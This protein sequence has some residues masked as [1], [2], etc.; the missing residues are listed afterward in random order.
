M[1]EPKSWREIRR[2][3][4]LDQARMENERRLLEAERKLFELLQRRGLSGE[5]LDHEF[6]EMQSAGS[7]AERESDPVLSVLGGYVRALGGEL[8]VSAAFPDE[9]VVLFGDRSREAA[10]P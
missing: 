3:R 10:A 5:Q 4:P 9:T 8:T 7:A 6:A 1:A 2:Q